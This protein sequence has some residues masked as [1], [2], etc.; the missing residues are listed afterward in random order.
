MKIIF[1]LVV[2]KPKAE[3]ATEKESEPLQEIEAEIE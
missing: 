1:A 3:A 2:K